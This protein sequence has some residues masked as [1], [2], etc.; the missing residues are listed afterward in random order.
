MI[1]RALLTIDLTEAALEEAL[2]ASGDLVVA[3]HPPIFAP[4]K[5]HVQRDAGQRTLL[6]AAAAG[7]APWSPHTALDAMPG[8]VNDWM[9]GLAGA[10]TG[11][12]PITP[13]PDAPATG[14]GRI[15]RLREPALLDALVAR[16]KQGLGLPSVRLA[17]GADAPVSTLTVCPG[18]GGRLFEGVYADLLVTGEMRRRS[19]LRWREQYTALWPRLRPGRSRRG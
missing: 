8:G 13:R 10:V 5:R 15:A 3:Y 7:I 9:L 12:A 16:F 1:R 18:A 19:V 17:R 2:N 14:P 6:R 11:V 4:L